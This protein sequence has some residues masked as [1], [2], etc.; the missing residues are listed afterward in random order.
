MPYTLQERAEIGANLRRLRERHSLSQEELGERVLVERNTVSRWELGQNV[1]R[2]S[3]LRR[4]CGAFGVQVGDLVPLASNGDAP[5]PRPSDLLGSVPSAFSASALKGLWCTSFTFAHHRDQTE[6][7]HVDVVRISAASDRRVQGTNYPPEPR[8]EDRA[9]PFRNAVEAELVGRHLVG[10]WKNVSD[11]RYFGTLQLAVLPGEDVM[12]GFYSGVASDVDVSGGSWTWVRLEQTD[13]DLVT[14]VLKDPRE[15]SAVLEEH[16]QFDG[17]LSLAA[18]TA[19]MP[20][21]LALK[22]N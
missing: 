1:P 11:T 17:P 3:E 16:S 9:S 12:R 4:I 2:R 7:Y 10:H 18:V 6:R 15:V 19:G 14:V 20:T 13:E 5:E 8:T 21:A 22:E